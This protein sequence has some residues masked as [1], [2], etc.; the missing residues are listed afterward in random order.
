M[1]TPSISEYWNCE[2]HR[3]RPLFPE[4]EPFLSQAFAEAAEGSE[5]VLSRYRDNTE[6]RSKPKLLNSLLRRL[7]FSR[8]FR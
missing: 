1:D 3:E 7:L 6:N 5:Y 2:V 8:P 4:L